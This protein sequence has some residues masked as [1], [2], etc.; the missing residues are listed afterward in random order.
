[1]NDVTT[2]NAKKRPKCCCQRPFWNVLRKKGPQAL[3]FAQR[4]KGTKSGV[5]ERRKM[6]LLLAQKISW[7][8]VFLR[9][10]KSSP[11][12]KFIACQDRKRL[13]FN[14]NLNLR[15]DILINYFGKT[16]EPL[17]KKGTE[18]A[19]FSYHAESWFFPYYFYKRGPFIMFQRWVFSFLQ[20]TI[21]D[22]G[23]IMN[24]IFGKLRRNLFC[25]ATVFFSNC[26]TQK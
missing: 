11:F 5:S 21:I 17:A 14:Q 2:S 15:N 7:K 4:K 9:H 6:C 26:A 24:M 1:M 10:E 25:L 20:K 12:R 18:H 22:K 19:I 8:R 13:F 3:T 16:I 23:W